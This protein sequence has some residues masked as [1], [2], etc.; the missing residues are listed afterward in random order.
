V[1]RAVRQKHVARQDIGDAVFR[2][3]LVGERAPQLGDAVVGHI[4]RL[5]RRAGVANRC[6]DVRCDGEAR[7]TRLEA[8]DARTFG[9][10]PQQR[11][12]DLD[13]FP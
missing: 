2:S 3:Q 13:D 1:H 11:F 9:L 8:Y 4:V 10:R 7:I 5:P 12:T 6:Q